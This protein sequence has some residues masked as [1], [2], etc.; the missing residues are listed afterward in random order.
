MASQASSILLVEDD[1]NDVF[2]MERAMSKANLGGPIH[3]A[4][5]GQEAIDYL[6]GKGKFSDRTIYPLPH[7]I[8]LDLKLPFIHGFEVLEWIR[9]QPSLQ[10]INVLILTSS[11]ED[12]DRERA[13]QL[14]AKA[15]LVKPPTAQSLLE[16]IQYLPECA[17]QPL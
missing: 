8:F 3:V 6:S 12:R 17:P 11:G 15:Y 13:N 16:V 2:L 5:N 1:E 14:G 10:E 9:T 4:V 7:C